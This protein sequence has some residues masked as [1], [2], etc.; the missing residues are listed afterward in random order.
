MLVRTGSEPGRSALGDHFLG[1]TLISRLAFYPLAA[2]FES[3]D[4]IAI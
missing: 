2:K 3:A 4:L 1:K